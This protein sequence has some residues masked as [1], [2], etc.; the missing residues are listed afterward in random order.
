MH[1]T[2]L[3][4]RIRRQTDEANPTPCSHCFTNIPAGPATSP[5]LSYFHAGIAHFCCGS[6]NCLGYSFFLF[7]LGNDMLEGFPTTT[8]SA[9]EMVYDKGQQQQVGSS[10]Y[11]DNETKNSN[12]S[13][14]FRLPRV[15]RSLVRGSVL[16][17]EVSK[18]SAEGF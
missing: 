14:P 8:C 6:R 16:H 12:Y 3:T 17:P 11:A 15:V 10:E 5:R 13:S 18:P 7:L 1:A 9:N 2:R 4:V